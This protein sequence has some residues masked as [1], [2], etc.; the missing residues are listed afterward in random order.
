MTFI[1]LS[2]PTSE[3]EETKSGPRTWSQA[4]K[5]LNLS[6]NDIDRWSSLLLPSFIPTSRLWEELLVQPWVHNGDSDP[7]DEKTGQSVLSVWIH[8]PEP[9]VYICQVPSGDS[10]AYCGIQYQRQD[11][12]LTHVR[13]HLNYKPFA[14]GG[15]C[16]IKGCSDAF[17][18]E[19]Y[20]KVHVQ[21]VRKECEKCGQ[22]YLRQNIKR[23]A[24]NC[25]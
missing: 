20:L 14:C 2:R 18:S 4:L 10:G 11:R 9:R 12:A 8:N 23:H 1:P 25:K 15:R 16:G 22:T 6:E 17:T 7:L 5:W 19:A 24:A 13:T 21:P 3:L